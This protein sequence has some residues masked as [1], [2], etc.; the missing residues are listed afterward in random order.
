[1][2]FAN[3]NVAELV[4]RLPGADAETANKTPDKVPDKAKSKAAS[5]FTGPQPSLADELVQAVLKGG[6]DALSDLVGLLRDP[7]TPEFDNFKA[8]YLLHCVVLH[9]GK[10][11]NAAARELVSG[12]LSSRCVDA[13][14]PTYVRGFLLRELQWCG[15]AANAAAIGPLLN[16]PAL[17]RDAAAALLSIGGQAATTQFRAAW[18]RAAGPCR[19]SI[20]HGLAQLRDAQSLGVF[21]QALGSSQADERIVAALAIS[22]LAEAPASSALLKLADREE[23]FSRIRATH[24]CLRMADRFAAAGKIAPA[25]E[26]YTHLRDTRKDKHERHFRA[27]ADRA[28]QS[29]QGKS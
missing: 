10:P 2:A 24:A 29:L 3:V 16:E 26:I 14:L 28:L 22:E 9:A 13:K 11:D 1:M 25:K 19:L 5:K 15:T 23:G 4:A 12:L 7:A 6:P 21:Q 18:G 8:E 20:L 17:C 27:E